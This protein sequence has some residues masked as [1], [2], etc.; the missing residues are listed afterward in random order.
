M[1]RLASLTISAD[2]FRI[3]SIRSILP[4]KVGSP[5]P[6]AKQPWPESAVQRDLGRD[7]TD[8]LRLPLMGHAKKPPNR[9]HRERE[10]D[11][12]TKWGNLAM[13]L[14]ETTQLLPGKS[15][16]KPVTSA[17]NSLPFVERSAR[18]QIPMTEL[19]TAE[20]AARFVA[21]V[22]APGNRTHVSP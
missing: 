11:Y 21:Q 18:F 8:V 15:S 5:N 13:V 12:A 14:A 2:S 7:S 22:A 10:Q 20:F 6:S 1:K 3:I 16:A 19:M 17:A 4:H 9:G